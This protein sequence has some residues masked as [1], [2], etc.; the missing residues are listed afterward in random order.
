MFC[1]VAWVVKGDLTG[2]IPV[3]VM[4]VSAVVMVLCG[5]GRSRKGLGWL[6]DYALPISLLAG[7]LSA[8]PI[9]AWLS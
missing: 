1:D 4:T 8:I 9:T 3:A 5:L 2:L 7:M 6:N